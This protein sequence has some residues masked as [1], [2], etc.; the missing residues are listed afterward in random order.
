MSRIKKTDADSLIFADGDS[1]PLPARDKKRLLQAVNDWF[2]KAAR[3][4][5]DA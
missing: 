2:W 3:G 1:V 4:E 5:Q